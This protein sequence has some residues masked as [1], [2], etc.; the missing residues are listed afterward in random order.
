MYHFLTL[1]LHNIFVIITICIH[2]EYFKITL[3]SY[4]NDTLYFDDNDVFL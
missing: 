1:L 2:S 4:G 3:H